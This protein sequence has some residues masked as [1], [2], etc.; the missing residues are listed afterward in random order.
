MNV[1][2]P[3]RSPTKAEWPVI[4]VLQLH[5]YDSRANPDDVGL[6]RCSCGLNM[7][8]SQYEP[9]LAQMI[10]R[11]DLKLQ[12]EM[13]EKWA[14]LR[15]GYLRD[16]GVKEPRTATDIDKLS[17]NDLLIWAEAEGVRHAAKLLL[18]PRETMS[19]PTWLEPEWERYLDR[20]GF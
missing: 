7:Y 5:R 1:A 16:H 15:L 17:Q 6:G 18:A 20:E 4:D 8:W 13:L 10:V 2:I 11:A 9:H 3:H 19:I 14:D 12:S